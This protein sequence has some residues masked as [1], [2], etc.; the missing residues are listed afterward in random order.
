[1]KVVGISGSLRRGSH[2]TTL[3]RAAAE[4][5]PPPAELQIFGGLK[6]VPPYDEDDDVQGGPN[7]AAE[8]RRA[9]ATADAILIATPEY[10]SSIPGQLKNALDWASRPFPAN[11]LQGKPVAV[12]GASTGMFGAVWSQAEARKVLGAIGARVI[13]RDLPVPHAHQAFT[14]EGRL[15]DPELRE[16]Y[17]DIL[18]ELVALADQFSDSSRLAA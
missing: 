11:A 5:L 17:A 15:A 2:N 18:G 8:L 12:V 14:D 16:R 4:L 6:V 9:I 3:L 7:A 13:E 1:M 10:N